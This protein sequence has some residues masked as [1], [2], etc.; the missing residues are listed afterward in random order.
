MAPGSSYNYDV[1]W[2]D[3]TTTTGIIVGTGFTH[4]Y[5][6]SGIY[7]ITITG[8]YP[9][10][11]FNNGGDK[12][13][14]ISIDQWGINPWT[15]MEN[16]FYG[17]SN[18]V[19]SATDEPN[20][21][22]VTDMSSMFRGAT[23]FNQDIGSWDVSNV[24]NMSS[25][26]FGASIFNQN[27][28][29][30]DVGLVN[31]FTSMFRDASL[32]NSNI[33][34]WNVSNALSFNHMF[35]NATSFD[36]DLGSWDITGINSSGSSMFN[37]FDQSGLSTPNYDSTLIFW[38][39][40]T[41]LLDNVTITFSPAQYCLGKLA[42][43]KLMNNHNWT[44]NDAGQDPGCLCPGYT[45]FRNGAWSNGVPT[46][47]TTAVIEDDYDTAI[48]GGGFSACDLQVRQ[49]AVLAIRAM[50]SLFIAGSLILS[51]EINVDPGGNIDLQGY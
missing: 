17:C 30:W 25:M 13:K 4:T 43:E 39:E 5:A 22:N 41:G 11:P 51:G 20:L 32:F 9:R 12:L 35:K 40:L 44:I 38:S 23:S 21:T 1:D 27:L 19:I 42:R 49:D 16:A 8:L 47:S 46:I 31:Y 33:G 24:T 3:G 10:M 6:S 34:T 7:Q 26:L 18:L 36:Q 2:G 15:S 45:V 28:S 50:D 29:S 14:I 37:M 48:N